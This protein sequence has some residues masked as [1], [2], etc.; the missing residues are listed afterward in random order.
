MDT[1]TIV[2]ILQKSAPDVSLEAATAID[3]PTLVVPRERLV[4]VCHALRH[5]PELDFGLLADVTAVDWW[6]REPRFAII[7]HLACVE[8]TA[9]GAPKR[10]RLKVL[11]P[12]ADARVPTVSEIWPSANWAER[13]VW[14]LVG[15]VFDGHPDL[16]RL[17]MPDDWEGHPL[18]KDYPVQVAV[19]AKVAEPLQLTPEQFVANIEASRVRTGPAPSGEAA[20]VPARPPGATPSDEGGPA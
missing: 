9:V 12:G 14:D 19:P 15:I 17:L 3:Q 20:R 8:T 16:R 13:E 6:P 18:R 11:V 7:Y 10:L 2:S 5:E 1:A 4:D